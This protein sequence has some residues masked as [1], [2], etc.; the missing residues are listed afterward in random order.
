[1][2]LVEMNVNKFATWF[3]FLNFSAGKM[4]FN[5][6]IAALILSF[7]TSIHWFDLFTGIFLIIVSLFW[8]LPLS[9]AF[10]QQESEKVNSKL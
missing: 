3:Y 1:M 2:I 10:R 6:F 9:I 8:Y 4:S 5:L 7:G